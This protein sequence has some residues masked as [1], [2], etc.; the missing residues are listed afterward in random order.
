M[1]LIVNKFENPNLILLLLELLLIIDVLLQIYDGDDDTATPLWPS[2]ADISV[3]PTNLNSATG[4][5]LIT[6][7]TSA[8]LNDIGFIASFATGKIFRNFTMGSAK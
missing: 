2:G 6:F 4:I 7:T 1:V 8:I 5:F 3:A